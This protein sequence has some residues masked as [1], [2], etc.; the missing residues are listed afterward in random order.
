MPQKGAFLGTNDNDPQHKGKALADNG[1]NSTVV[2]VGRVP[3]FQERAKSLGL[4]CVYVSNAPGAGLRYNFGGSQSSTTCGSLRFTAL[5]NGKAFHMTADVVPGG[6]RMLCSRGDLGGF[7]IL[8][9][10]R[11]NAHPLLQVSGKGSLSSAS[12]VKDTGQTPGGHML[13]DLFDSG[14]S[15]RKAFL[16][17][18]IFQLS[19]LQQFATL[20][21]AWSKDHEP[22]LA[23][24]RSRPSKEG[25]WRSVTPLGWQGSLDILLQAHETSFSYKPEGFLVFPGSA[26]RLWHSPLCDETQPARILVISSAG[27]ALWHEA[28]PEALHGLPWLATSSISSPFEPVCFV[29]TQFDP[30]LS[31]RPSVTSCRWQTTLVDLARKTFPQVENTESNWNMIDGS[32]AP[33]GCVPTDISDTWKCESGLSGFLPNEVSCLKVASDSEPSLF[34]ILVDQEAVEGRLKIFWNRRFKRA[35]EICELEVEESW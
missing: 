12:K 28:S 24:R 2:G 16:S 5:V 25:E 15:D 4:P 30:T 14:K 27:D 29:V 22:P 8:I 33:T 6:M 26:I 9:D 11:K 35:K 10:T 17:S 3:E 32:T 7:G 18:S 31:K 20:F 23:L 34:A 1:C 13:I 21:R 19:G